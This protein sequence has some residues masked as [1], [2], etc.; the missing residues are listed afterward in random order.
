MNRLSVRRMMLLPVLLL[1]FVAVHSLW[2]ADSAAILDRIS[3]DIRYLASDELEGRGPG[4]EGLDKAKRYIRQ[5]FEDM[6][7]VGAGHD[8]AYLRPF[9][10]PLR[11]TVVEAKTFLTL[12]GPEELAL[13]LEPGKRFQSVSTRSTDVKTLEIVFAGYGIS[14][15][16]LGYDD[17]ENI[18]VDG[19]AVVIMRREPR[20]DS[21]DSVFCGNG[22]S[23]HAYMRRKIEV[24]EKEGAAALL[25]VN[26]VFMTRNEKAD[27]LVEPG[28][29]GP[30]MGNIPVLHVKQA[31]VD[32]VLRS[33][34]LKKGEETFSS[35]AAVAAEIDAE[36]TPISQPLPNWR[37]TF[38]SVFETVKIQVSNVAAVIPGAGPQAT[39]TIVIGAHYDHLGYGSTGGDTIYNGA[40]DNATGTAAVLELARR[41]AS[42]SERPRR[43]LLFIAFTAEERGL[44]GSNFY[45]KD[46]LVPLDDTVAM[47]NFDMIGHLDAGPLTLAGVKSAKSFPEMV[48]RLREDEPFEV[49]PRKVRGGSDHLG[50]RRNAVPYLF[51]H[52]GVTQT[53][54]TPD[55]DVHTLDLPGVVEVIDFAEDVVDELLQMRAGP[56]F[57]KDDADPGSRR[58]KTYLGI[59]PEYFGQNREGV[60]CVQVKPGSPAAKGKLKPGDVIVSIGDVE[61]LDENGLI[62][63]LKKF[64]PGDKVDVIVRRGER[65]KTLTVTLGTLDH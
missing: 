48:A 63:A 17:Y 64:D 13:Q 43:R 22:V 33:A 46:P 34:P 32:R 14:A 6:G 23:S 1:L 27:A 65:E 29:F 18:D 25:L 28:G 19:K 10:M 20:Q 50:F 9:S 58:V 44:V 57:T 11:A 26:D 53:Y 45:V 59:V 60:T 38:R 42:R 51:F 52:T 7:L 36:L 41:F 4:T 39:E 12:R 56:E 2:A 5:T 54:H 62:A 16:G 21:E 8:G 37:V 15:P 49:K 24:A 35:L 31:V 30:S 55:D 61:I 40:D 3:S 47:L